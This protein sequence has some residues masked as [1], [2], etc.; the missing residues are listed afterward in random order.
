MKDQCVAVVRPFTPTTH[1]Y[2]C[3][4][5]RKHGMFCLHH[6]ARFQQKLGEHGMRARRTAISG[7]ALAR[8]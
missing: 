6:F 8:M 2:R 1:A 7:G 4:K 3:T 5:T